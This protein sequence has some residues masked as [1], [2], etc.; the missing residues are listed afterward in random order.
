M[1]RA[2]LMAPMMFALAI[3][4]SGAVSADPIADF[5]KNSP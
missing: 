2:V 1:K 4:Q 5:Y 3:A